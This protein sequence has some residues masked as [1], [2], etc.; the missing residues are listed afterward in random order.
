MRNFYRMS[1]LISFM[2]TLCCLNFIATAQTIT[3]IPAP[4][5]G[6]N[7]NAIS[8]G[9][10]LY[11][12]GTIV[13]GDVPPNSGNKPVLVF[14]H[15]YTGNADTWFGDNNDMYTKAYNDGYRTAFTVVYPDRS[16]WANGDMFS[17]QLTA[18]CNY[19]G[20]NKVVVVAHSKGGIDTDAAIVHYGAGNRVDRVITLGSP[21]FGT[22]LAN[23]AQSGWVWWLSA[24]FG[25]RNEATY[26]MQTGYMDYFRSVTDNQ[27]TN[28][29]SF[30]TLGSGSYYGSL[31]TSG[32][33]LSANG[34]AWW[35]G[36]NDG[37]VNYRD[38]R[39]P[40]STTL[41]K[42]SY[43]HYDL[44]IGSNVWGR[45]KGQLPSSLSREMAVPD[46]A[47]DFNPN[48]IVRSNYQ[49][50]SGEGG[51]YNFKLEEDARSVFVDVRQQS[52]SDAAI[53]QNSSKNSLYTSR[54]VKADNDMLGQYSTLI[55][56][57][58]P[59]SGN[60]QLEAKEPFVA[61]I[62]SEGSGYAEL[63]TDLSG[64]RRVYQAGEVM[65]LRL[66]LANA[67]DAGIANATV[68]GTL[69][70]TVNLLGEATAAEGQSIALNFEATDEPGVYT[71]SSPPLAWGG[72]YNISIPAESAQLT[73]SL[74]HSIAVANKPLET[75]I[76]HPMALTAYPN[77]S[78]GQVVQLR[79]K[80]EA[81]GQVGIR[82]L[83]VK[84]SSVYQWQGIRPA[85]EHD[86]PIGATLKP[87]F[88]IIQLE[89]N[90]QTDQQKLLITE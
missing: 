62:S 42:V 55:K 50:I 23:L 30:R 72:I 61:I 90:G 81:E 77:P 13:V 73:R 24:I 28:R 45:V 11:D 63:S 44:A 15:G 12:P 38:S 32:V 67:Q 26:V 75:S 27:S 56:M 85:G 49:I 69:R 40:N 17:Q 86:L 36:G 47:S 66:K 87:G 53:I 78:N 74:T 21:H 2:L 41:S 1:R 88:Y 31:W 10:D 25:Q 51:T 60:Y 8:F 65:N 4:A 52:A 59:G 76:D 54:K 29:V 14:I 5:K 22:P 35:N 68:T 20:V 16:M 64:S 58:N 57:D 70:R 18:I 46:V 83:D 19:F 33:Y 37:V 48:A 39:R 34:G 89:S 79:Y 84:G 43:N 9:S 6:D 71:V 7:I 82:L 3:K 80:L